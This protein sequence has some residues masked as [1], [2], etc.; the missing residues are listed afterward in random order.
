[1][2]RLVD[3]LLD[4]SRIEAGRWQP[5]PRADVDVGRRGPG[6]VGR[7]RRTGR[8]APAW[9][10]RVDVAARRRH[11]ARRS[12]RASARCS[13]T[14]STTRCATRRRAAAS[15]A[16]AG[17]SSGGVAVSVRDTGA[18]ITREH[19][20]R[21]F[22]RFYRADPS[23]S[24]EEGGTGLGLAIV[25]HL[26][27]AHGGRVCAESERGSGTTVT[28]C[29]P[30]SRSHAGLLAPPLAASHPAPRCASRFTASLQPQGP[31]VTARRLLISPSA[32]MQASSAHERERM[33]SLARRFLGG[34]TLALGDGAERRSGAD[35]LPERQGHR[36]PAGAVLLLRQ[37]GLR[38]DHRSEEQLLHPARPHRGPGQ[39]LG[40][41]GGLHPAVVRG[42]PEPLGRGHHLH[43]SA[44]PAGGGTPTITCRTTGRSGLRLRDAW[45]D[46][47]FTKEG[48][49]GR[50]LPPRRARR[51]GPTAATS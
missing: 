35:D 14:C 40:E 36:P 41:R 27:E 48:N 2:Q 46:V 39:H 34:T 43:L 23:R 21:I 38:G 51:S 7:A 1:M 18:G 28:C 5:E 30:K 25:K 9:S 45:I 4:L 47:R 15:P 31:L 32:V 44:V 13:P 6:G 26:V 8:R 3:D 33:R 19:L 37:R 12:R 42:R 50:V 24:R 17:G 10:S 11:R 29:F 16:G 20:P 49:Q 22:E